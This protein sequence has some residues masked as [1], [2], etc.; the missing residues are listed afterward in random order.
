MAED[1]EGAMTELTSQIAKAVQKPRETAFNSAELFL[2]LLDSELHLSNG[3]IHRKSQSRIY[4]E[5]AFS[6][7]ER[8][9]DGKAVSDEYLT[10]HWSVSLA[11]LDVEKLFDETSDHAAHSLRISKPVTGR[12]PVLI[13]SEVLAL[14]L[15]AQLS[16]LS[17]VA[18]Y[19]RLPHVS[20][21]EELVP[22][23]EGDL[24]SMT[25]DPLLEYGAD[26]TAISDQGS[27]QKILKLVEKNKVQAI[28]A[29]AQY[30]Q[31][32]GIAPTTVRGNLVIEPGSCG[33]DELVHSAPQVIEVLQFSSI[34]PDPN[35]GTFSSEIRLARLHD[36]VRGTVTYLKGG[37]LSGSL[38]ENFKRVKLSSS[39]VK[40][41]H[42]SSDLPQGQGYYGPEHALL[43]DV[44]VVG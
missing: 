41:A 32:L 35:S 16:R 24:L 4:V 14:V 37:S 38:G 36:N 7:T 5:A 30:A 3:L 21:G 33:Y 29:D 20:P 9:S 15:G 2:S 44:S 17:G 1:L 28:S 8:G 22:G 42:F 31:Y 27:P 19:N 40:R 34:F 18:H 23:A 43:N 6:K 10:T 13:D 39:R 25:L 11:D 26:T 12:Y